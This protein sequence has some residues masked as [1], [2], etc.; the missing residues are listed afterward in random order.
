MPDLPVKETRLSELHLPEIKRDDIVRS[1]SEMRMPDA[2]SNF[3]WP[4]IERP[5]VDVGKAVASAAAAAHI[6]RRSK[7]PTWPFAVVGLVVA[8]VAAVVILT[9]DV[10]RARLS[11][12]VRAI[13]G[14]IADMRMGNDY[15][16]DIERD[17]AIAFDAAPTA[18]IE[19][20]PFTDVTMGETTGYPEGLGSTNGESNHAVE[21]SAAKRD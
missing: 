19:T 2:V 15:E 11:G 5:S 3:E 1:L 20:S 13:R 8:G 14:Q 12:A 4:K 18:P 21:A 7:R 10:V 9:N 16:L 17:D 6:T